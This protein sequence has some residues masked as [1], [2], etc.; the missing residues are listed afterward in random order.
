MIIEWVQQCA[1]CKGTGLYVGFAERDGAGVVCQSCKG[2]GRRQMKVEYKEFTQRLQRTDV[3]HVYRTNPGIVVDAGK[4]VSGGVSIREW[5]ADP[6]SCEQPGK[7][8]RQHT[9]PAWW[10][11]SADYSKKPD[12][13]ECMGVG[14]FADC[15]QFPDKA[16]CW[17]RWDKEQVPHD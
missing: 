12:W 1:E 13:K 6:T 14:A 11:Q 8:M 4:T 17:Q 2:S 3:T 10:Y 7:E 16:S 5:E 9:C 15:R